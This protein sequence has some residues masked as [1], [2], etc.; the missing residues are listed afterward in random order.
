MNKYSDGTNSEKC[1]AAKKAQ[2]D[3]PSYD[4]NV[5][6]SRKFGA[7]SCAFFM[8]ASTRNQAASPKAIC[9]SAR[10]TAKALLSHRPLVVT[11]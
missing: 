9:E 5:P 1:T 11:A 6:R 8:I 10:N 7:S 4:A 2:N 3:H